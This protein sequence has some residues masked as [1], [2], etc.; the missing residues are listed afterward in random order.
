VCGASDTVVSP[1]PIGNVPVGLAVTPD[2]STVYVA[3]NAS[4]TVSVINTGTNTVTT[5]I[6]GGSG[7]WGVAVTPDGSTVYVSNDI[8]STVSAIA[9]ATN[10]VTFTIPVGPS[11][12]G[13]SVTPDGDVVY[14]ANGG[15]NTVSVIAT[16]TNTVTATVTVGSEPLAFGIFII[17]PSFAGTPH[18]S[19][20]HGQS[21]A[22]LARQ[23]GGFSAAT[24]ALG[25]PG[26]KALQNAIRAFCGG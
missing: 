24:A 3:N 23:Y 8:G 7:P 15:S 11:P 2:G 19:N 14:V 16:A 9:T 22:A 10:T 6:P 25:F 26:E 13:V 4:N 12:F 18:F 21:V 1:I 17:R 5:T 20:C